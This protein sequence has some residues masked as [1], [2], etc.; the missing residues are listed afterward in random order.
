MQSQ[1]PG[2]VFAVG[3]C[4]VESV[5]EN[6]P[7]QRV[8]RPTLLRCLVQSVSAWDHS[9]QMVGPQLVS[10]AYSSVKGERKEGTYPAVVVL[11]SPII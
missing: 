8:P 7:S 4:A 5:L 1:D 10:L 11:I 9:P 3:Q 2:E 6:V